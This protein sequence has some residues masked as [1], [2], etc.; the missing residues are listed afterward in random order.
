MI[1]SSISQL[2]S[3]YNEV[4]WSKTI[5][6]QIIKGPP[7]KTKIEKWDCKWNI[8]Y[9]MRRLHGKNGEL[10]GMNKEGESEIREE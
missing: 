9:N 10:W 7:P 5:V 3:F 2:Q 4:R 1:L 8:L 6:L